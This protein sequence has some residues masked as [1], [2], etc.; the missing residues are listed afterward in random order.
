MK[1]GSQPREERKITKGRKEDYQSMEGSQ[2]REGRK[3][4]EVGKE[5]YQGKE[6]R[7][8]IKE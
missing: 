1:K 2:L 6:G 5:D 4:T 7:K 8:A 3:S